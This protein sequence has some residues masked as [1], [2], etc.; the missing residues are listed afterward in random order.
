VAVRTRTLTNLLADVR[1]QADQLGATLRNTDP[2]LTRALNQSIQAFREWISD[3]GFQYYL[4]PSSGVC[5]IGA[6]S[7]YAFGLLDISA[8]SPAVVRVYGLDLTVNNVIYSLDAVTFAERNTFQGFLSDTNKSGIPIAFSMYTNTGV[9]LLP[10]AQ[11]AY[12]YTLWYLPVGTDLTAG[13]DTFDGI[14]GWEEWLYWDMLVKLVVRESDAAKAQIASGERERVQ[15]AILKRS[16]HLQRQGPSIK[17]DTRG[18][19]LDKR[20]FLRSNWRL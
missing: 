3:N 17:R 4:R 12:P 7:P 1:W 14:A 6:T 20:R 15:A 16:R 18:E 11:A 8:I 19:K 5:P 2:D 9:A 10:P 13:S